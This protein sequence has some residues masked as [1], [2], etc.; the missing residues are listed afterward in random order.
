M[1][2]CHSWNILLKRLTF[3]PPWEPIFGYAKG[4]T[5]NSSEW[6]CFTPYFKNNVWAHVIVVATAEL[7]DWTVFFGVICVHTSFLD[8]TWHF[9]CKKLLTKIAKNAAVKNT[10]IAL[11]A[12]IVWNFQ[13]LWSF[14][15]CS[16][17]VLSNSFPV[18]RKDLLWDVG[19]QPWQCDYGQ[20]H[21]RIGLCHGEHWHT[22]LLVSK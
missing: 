18:W 17:F 10:F 21:P 13:T 8:F 16:C 6:K 5:I 19:L 20:W 2:C 12:V 4:L 15:A 1:F 7:S 9:A 11:S 14:K 3:F 22:S